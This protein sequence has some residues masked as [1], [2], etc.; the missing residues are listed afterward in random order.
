[1][2]EAVFSRM[3]DNRLIFP[4]VLNPR[5]ILECG[6]GS[7]SWAVKVAEE[8]PE[9]E[10]GRGVFVSLALSSSFP[11]S[12]SQSSPCS[13]PNLQPKI[14]SSPGPEEPEHT[15]LPLFFQEW[16]ARIRH[17]LRR[18]LPRRSSGINKPGPSRHSWAELGAPSRL[19]MQTLLTRRPHG[20]SASTYTHTRSQTTFLRI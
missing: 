13:R 2:M 1:M 15:H 8:H 14:A 19:W 16:G 6:F 12:S 11:L 18:P 3:F 10:V 9:C 17:T 5:R 4:P 20:L 7:A